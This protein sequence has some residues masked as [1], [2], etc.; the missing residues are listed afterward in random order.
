[1][2]KLFIYYSNTGNG[3][4]LANLLAEQQFELHKVETIKPMKKM[5]FFRIFYYGMIAGTGKKLAIKDM[6]L[7]F[8]L[9]DDEVVI[10]SPIWNDRLSNPVLTLLDKYD[11]NKETTTFVLYS[12]G[13][14]AEHAKAQLQKLGFKKAPIILKQPLSNKE[15]ASRAIKDL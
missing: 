14:K 13:G 1:M 9:V 12:G 8:N 6:E 3:D 11:F 15:D 7:I 2:K 5:N 4:Y 10:G